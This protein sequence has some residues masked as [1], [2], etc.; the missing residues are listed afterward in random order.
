MVDL[1][2][3]DGTFGGWPAVF[4]AAKMNTALL[5][6]LTHH[7]GIIVTGN[8]LW[9]FRNRARPRSVTDP[10]SRHDQFWACPGFVRKRCPDH[11]LTVNS[12]AGGRQSSSVC[13]L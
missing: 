1:L 2:L 7:Y 4:V 3:D 8:V 12:T 9:R 5:D 10:A 6:Q 13:G 11:A